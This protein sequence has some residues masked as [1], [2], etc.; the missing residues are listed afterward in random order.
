MHTTITLAQKMAYRYVRDKTTIYGDVVRATHGETRNEV[1]G[2]GSGS[3]ELQQFTLKAAP[4]TFISA[5]TAAGAKSTLGVTANG[6]TWSECDDLNALGPVDR[7]FITRTDNAGKTTIVFGDGVHGER[8]PTGSEN[9]KAVYRFGIGAPGNVDAGQITLLA[10]RP[11][12]V[13]AVVNPQPATGG[14]DPEDLEQGRSNVPLATAALERIV[15]VD[16]YAAFARTF[17]GVAK[18]KAARF[19]GAPPLVHVTIAGVHDAPIEPGSDL[20]RNLVAALLAAGDP[21]Q[22]LDVQPRG[23]MALVLSA[24]VALLPNYQWEVV[25]AAIRASLLDTFGFEQRG[26]AEIVYLSEVISAMQAVAGVAYVG[27]D[28]FDAVSDRAALQDLARLS[29]GAEL[30][31]RIVPGLAEIRPDGTVAP[32][33]IAIFEP[34][35]PEAIVLKET[36]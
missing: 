5:P 15:S 21:Q 11:L 26:I 30:N 35:L 14:A 16:D 3:L 10:S 18:A 29:L 31:D 33:Q 12:G 32:A 20:V 1:L 7:G 2:S 27:V 6:V 36:T 25:S 28:G 23:L 22:A 19:A 4:L 8:L 34:S 24:R 17:A 13:K 9:V